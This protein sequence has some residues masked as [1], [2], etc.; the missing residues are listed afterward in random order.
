[1]LNT[2]TIVFLGNFNPAIFQTQWLDRYKILPRQDIQWA[3][4]ENAEQIKL[5]DLLRRKKDN[6]SPPGYQIMLRTK[7]Q[8]SY[9]L[10]FFV[11]NDYVKLNN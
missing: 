4:G 11:K 5:K 7:V 3:E 8:K 6:Q 10:L 1:M 2:S 9:S